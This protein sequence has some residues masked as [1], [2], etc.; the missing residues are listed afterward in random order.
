MYFCDYDHPSLLGLP[1][2]TSKNFPTIS[3]E[4]IPIAQD[5][6]DEDTTIHDDEFLLRMIRCDSDFDILMTADY[7][8]IADV[9]LAIPVFSDLLP[10]VASVWHFLPP[11]SV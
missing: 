5:A 10:T 3:F 11:A 9:G 7:I 2:D 4:N 1:T 8:I 6:S